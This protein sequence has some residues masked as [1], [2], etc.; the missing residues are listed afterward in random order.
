MEGGEL[1]ADTHSRV[2]FLEIAEIRPTRFRIPVRRSG[3][4][5]AIRKMEVT[6]FARVAM[7]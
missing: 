6:E 1:G 3:R 5:F 4:E 2:R 7:W